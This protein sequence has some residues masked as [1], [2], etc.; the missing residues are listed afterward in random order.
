MEIWGVES[1]VKMGR[2]SSA[3]V[4][5]GVESLKLT[6][7]VAQEGRSKVAVS[8]ATTDGLVPRGNSVFFMIT[9][10]YGPGAAEGSEDSSPSGRHHRPPG[11]SPL[12]SILEKGTLALSLAGVA[13]VTALPGLL[14]DERS[15]EGCEDCRRF[16][17]DPP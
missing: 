8:G 11:V 3:V 7:R 4:T 17:G 13:S 12:L 6:G 9:G 1:L 16:E 10:L 15:I 5:R 14:L 2:R